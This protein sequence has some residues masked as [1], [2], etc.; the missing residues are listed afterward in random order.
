MPSAGPVAVHC[1]ICCERSSLKMA[2]PIHWQ[3]ESRD[4]GEHRR[5]R[6]GVALSALPVSSRMYYLT[7]VDTTWRPADYNVR[8][9]VRGLKQ[10]PFNGYSEFRVGGA[11]RRYNQ[12]N[13]EQFMP[14]LMQGVGQR[15]STQLQ[16]REVAIVPIPGSTMAGGAPG[17][18]RI[19]DLA[20]MFARG[21][22]GPSKIVPAIRW[23]A[24]REKAHRQNEVRSPDLHQPRMRLAEQ[25]TKPVLLF[26]DVMTSGSQM[27]AATRFLREAGFDVIAGGGVARATKTQH[28]KMIGWSTDALL[29][30]RYVIHR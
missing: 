4:L 8:N 13:I 30:E 29:I 20:T 7:D 2:T 28:E 5:Y 26:D 6:E 11:V 9:I 27:I 21:Y 25:P 24:P 19:V 1:E 15:M 23:V 17:T 3:A 16:Q 14:P 12:A 10:E 18:F 22:G